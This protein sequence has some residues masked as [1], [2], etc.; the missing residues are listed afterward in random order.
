[1]GS[2]N[3]NDNLVH[4][5]STCAKHPNVPVCI[6]INPHV[7][8]HTLV[9]HI[10]STGGPLDSTITHLVRIVENTKTTA[11]GIHMHTGST[12]LLFLCCRNFYR[13]CCTSKPR[14]LDFGSDLK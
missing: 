3:V 14:I 4:I 8:V 2:S 12:F 7:Y 6:R 5:R 11:V 13:C 1:V 9:G 10:D